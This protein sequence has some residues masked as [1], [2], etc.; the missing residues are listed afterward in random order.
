[1]SSILRSTVKE[2][3]SLPFFYYFRLILN[4]RVAL[5][6][7]K[8]KCPPFYFNVQTP[9]R[10]FTEAD[11]PLNPDDVG[12]S[13][14]RPPD[15]QASASLPAVQHALCCTRLPTGSE[16]RL[17]H[18][19]PD[20]RHC[21][22]EDIQSDNLG[23]CVGRKVLSCQSVGIKSKPI[24]SLKIIKRK[25][26]SQNLSQLIRQQLQSD[27]WRWFWGGTIR[28]SPN[29]I[30]PS[31]VFHYF[32]WLL[33]KLPNFLFAFSWDTAGQERFKCIASSYYRQAQGTFYTPPDLIQL[34]VNNFLSIYNQSLL[35]NQ[36]KPNQTKPN[37]TEPIKP[38]QTLEFV[39]QR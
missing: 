10:H 37:W 30:Q 2:D 8:S 32:A 27:H 22:I 25:M 17:Y 7:A 29:A 20:H 16:I 34:I 12:S 21:R 15:S 6:N 26:F 14:K 1:M 13:S 28:H 33:F 38:N 35:T 19:Q 31:N 24:T 5:R 11:F 23:K 18:I 36:T 9:K 39:C 3:P 4:A